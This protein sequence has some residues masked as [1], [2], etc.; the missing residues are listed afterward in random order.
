MKGNW[1]LELMRIYWSVGYTCLGAMFQPGAY[2]AG[3]IQPG[4]KENHP[5]HFLQSYRTNY[6]Q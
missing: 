1:E 2:Q 5:G 4:L 3:I 6:T